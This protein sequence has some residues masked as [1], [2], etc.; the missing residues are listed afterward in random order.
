MSAAAHK[1][2]NTAAATATLFWI[3]AYPAGYNIGY[4]AL[5]YTYM[6]ELFPYLERSRGI[7]I[8]QFWGRGAG[9]MSTFVNPI[10][11]ENAK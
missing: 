3:F 9:F 5:S 7:S 8:F 4:N 10:G 11:L 1:S 6:V 2:K